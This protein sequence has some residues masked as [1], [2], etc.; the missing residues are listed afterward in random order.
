MLAFCFDPKKRQSK[1]PTHMSLPATWWSL[2]T[3]SAGTVTLEALVVM[4]EPQFWR[5][6]SP[7]ESPESRVPTPHFSPLTAHH[8]CPGFS[9]ADDMGRHLSSTIS[10][11]CTG[12][13]QL[14]SCC[15]AVYMNS[16]PLT[17]PPKLPNLPI[18]SVPR[19]ARKDDVMLYKHIDITSSRPPRLII[20]LL[21]RQPVTHCRTFPALLSR[22]QGVTREIQPLREP[23]QHCVKLASS[24]PPT[25]IGHI[26]TI[27][28]MLSYRTTVVRYNTRTMEFLGNIAMEKLLRYSTLSYRIAVVRVL[29]RTIA[30]NPG[31]V[32]LWYW[33]VAAC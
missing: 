22:C 25:C 9:H 6:P 4:V 33:Q 24:W 12:S 29:W 7:E 19:S 26:L 15:K 16:L 32:R 5:K 8:V 1:N 28:G 30:Q 18:T 21:L 31:T 23:Y 2:F 27:H 20:W 14:W 13:H 10:H 3:L 11:Q 17:R